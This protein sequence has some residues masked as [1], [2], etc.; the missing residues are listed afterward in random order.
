MPQPI[1]KT[2]RLVRQMTALLK[3]TATLVTIAN[4]V[5]VAGTTL[6]LTVASVLVNQPDGSTPS[7]PSCDPQTLS[8]QLIQET[9]RR[10]FQ[11]HP[12]RSKHAFIVPREKVLSEEWWELCDRVLLHR[13]SLTKPKGASKLPRIAPRHR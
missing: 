10:F 5:L 4:V 9:N 11:R 13:R 8:P 7:P 3:E 1:S 12:E 6:A 2:I